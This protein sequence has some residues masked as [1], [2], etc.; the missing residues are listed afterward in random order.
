[1]RFAAKLALGVAAATMTAP[2]LAQENPPAATALQKDGGDVVVIT[3]IGPARTADE[4]IA[5]TTVLDDT[6]IIER[7][8]GGL[9]DTLAGVPGVSSTAFG[10]GAS[11]PV[12]RGLGA[13]RVQVLINGIGVI[14]ASSA[15]PDHA[16]TGDP[17]GAER[18]EILRG[19]ATLAYGG[20]AAGGV[21]NVIDG[22]I[23]EE[24]PDAPFSATGYAGH[25]SVDDGNTLAA[26]GVGTAG[27]VVGVLSW[28]RRE[29]SDLEIPGLA[30][31][32]ALRAQEEAGGE[33]HEQ[34]SGTLENSGVESQA[35]SGGLSFV[36]DSGFIGVAVRRLEN[37]Y[38][39]VGGHAHEEEPAPAGLGPLA[40]GVAAV[41]E[42]PEAPF[43]DM[44]QTRYDVRGGW[45]F[46]DGFLDRV[47]GSLSLVDYEHTE[48]EGPGEPGTRFTNEGH[49]GRLEAQHV[50][51]GGWVGSIGV[52]TSRRDFRAV[53]DEAFV[54]P[55]V[56]DQHG[57][58]VFETYEIGDW[59]IEG[60]LRYDRVMVDNAING[61]ETFDTVN[62]SFGMHGHVTEN[63][64]LGAT[65]SRTERAPND[66]ELFADGPHLATQQ[67]EIGNPQLGT[68]RGVSLEGSARWEAGPLA[69][70]GSLYRFAFEDFIYLSPT[71][72]ELD[73]LP[74]FATLQGDATFTGGEIT[75]S[76][77]IGEAFGAN[78]TIDGAADAVRAKLDDGGDLPRIPPLS[79]MAGVEADAGFVKARLEVRWADRQDRVA[80][81]ELPT[82]GWTAVDLRTTWRLSPGVELIVDGANLTD[83]EIRY[84]A[85]PL[86]DLAPMAGRGLRIGLKAGF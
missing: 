11:R 23:V 1:M 67:Y 7:L 34:V 82:D 16:V 63:L 76:Y 24:L 8:G 80:D 53:G 49:E 17:L 12:I 18:I 6:A 84:H 51:L 20:G 72:A 60:G 58:F 28:T 83:E 9:G 4:L 5:S 38:G 52:Q 75:A 69:I 54:T 57:V 59:G 2:A 86:K 35:F 48:F 3:G 41:G 26:R 66:V 21:V 10:P 62:A 61:K 37:K 25:T 40:M 44:A 45:R 56:T 27:D 74:V 46:R 42:T 65:V 30:E 31:S 22:L 79:A 64:F 14:D 68:E 77:A 47:T 55:T 13:E 36:G 50:N 78:W 73:G 32:A 70:G 29:G 39:V 43:I 33:A 19:P 15:S 71:G 85:S 81:F